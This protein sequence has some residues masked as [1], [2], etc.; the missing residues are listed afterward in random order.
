[1]RCGSTSTLRLAAP[2]SDAASGWAPPIPPRPAVSTVLAGEVGGAPVL[3][4]GGHERLEGA[5]Q[6]AL[7]ADVNPRSGRHLPIHREALGLEQAKL[8][9]GGKSGHRA[10]SWPAAPVGRRDGYGRR[11]PACRTGRAASR[12]PR[13]R[14]GQPR[15]RAA[16]RGFG[17]PC[18]NRRRRSAGWDPRRPRGRGYSGACAAP[19]P[20]AS[21]YSEA[22]SL[23]GRESRS[24][25][26]PAPAP[27]LPPTSLPQPRGYHRAPSC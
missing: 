15:S 19:P 10:S 6:D 5:L 3:L 21:P 9:P 26:R 17:R 22:A 24:D 16:P 13:A 20:D 1:M 4:G 2:A 11:R 8:V 23:E 25:P 18:P 14:S 12:R 27:L 7:A